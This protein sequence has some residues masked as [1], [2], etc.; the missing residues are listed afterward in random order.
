MPPRIR[1]SSCPPQLL[2]HSLDCA[3]VSSLPPPTAL[4]LAS[5]PRLAAQSPPPVA[6]AQAQ[7][8]RAFSTTAAHQKSRVRE[9]FREWIA[10]YGAMLRHPKG[11]GST[12][13]LSSLQKTA[14]GGAE[15]APDQP[16]PSNPTFRSQPVL[17]ESAREAVWAAVMRQGLPIKA[18]SA[19][20]NVDVRRVAAVVRMKE[21]EKKWEAEVSRFFGGGFLFSS[22]RDWG[23]F[24]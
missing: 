18:V 14:F 7:G 23:L 10:V 9:R 4:L 24:L 8:S 12:N 21:I 22:R 19:R 2:L 5:T 20:F 1:G 16:F 15:V 17:S 3:P 6:Q 11:G 13:Y